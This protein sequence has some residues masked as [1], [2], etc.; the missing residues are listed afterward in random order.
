MSNTGDRVEIFKGDDGLW[1][2]RL[3]AANHK[4]IA[5]SG[6]S[7]DS[8]SNAKR[9]GIRVTGSTKVDVVE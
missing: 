5:T 1:R 9:A 6:E 2:W 4:I 7:F 8:K 3:K